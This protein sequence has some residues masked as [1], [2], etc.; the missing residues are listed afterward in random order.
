MVDNSLNGFKHPTIGH[1]LYCQLQSSRIV[2]VI[3][4]F[5]VWLKLH[6][7]SLFSTSSLITVS[8]KTLNMTQQQMT[9]KISGIRS[10]S[11]SLDINNSHAIHRK[12]RNKP[13]IPDAV[14]ENNL[15]PTQAS[16]NTHTDD[17]STPSNLCSPTRD[18]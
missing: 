12:S 9:K 14:E 8:P 18:I 11:T 15:L 5:N 1:Y 17:A 2:L 4:I 13:Q 3:L 16:N 10:F 7:G 6:T